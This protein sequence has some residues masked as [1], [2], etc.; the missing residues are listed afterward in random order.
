MTDITI[1]AEYL[2]IALIIIGALAILGTF[3][4]LI[5]SHNALQKNIRSYEQRERDRYTYDHSNQS[6]YVEF[7]DEVLQ[8]RYHIQ[9]ENNHAQA[10]DSAFRYKSEWRDITGER[11]FS[12]GIDDFEDQQ[13]LN[14]NGFGGSA[15]S[16]DFQN[17][18]TVEENSYVSAG[19]AD[20]TIEPDWKEFLQRNESTYETAQSKRADEYERHQVKRSSIS[21]SSVIDRINSAKTKGLANMQEGKTLFQRIKN[22]VKS[23]ITSPEDADARKKVS[24]RVLL[25]LLGVWVGLGLLGNAKISFLS[26][27]A[28]ILSVVCFF[29]IF[30]DIVLI[31]SAS[32]SKKAF[33]DITCPTCNQLITYGDNVR[34][35]IIDVR[36]RTSVDE[37]YGS[38][39]EYV[40]VRFDCVCQNCGTKKTF[41]HEF[42]TAIITASGRSV[43]TTS[44]RDYPLDEQIEDYFQGHLTIIA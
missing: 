3:I 42:C 26:P 5:H 33:I 12:A 1:K 14:N 40:K 17:A 18:G 39:K 31:V 34:K 7:G 36:N 38:L 43:I 13:Q 20:S 15:T 30:F 41:I 9:H 22:F 16:R 8:R 6:P 32:K 37:N 10:N 24:K 23:P 28:T 44:G 11:P 29:L 4:A 2:G 35:S 19:R 25:I 21:Q 27:I